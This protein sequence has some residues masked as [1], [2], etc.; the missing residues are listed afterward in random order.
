VLKNVAKSDDFVRDQDICG[1]QYKLLKTVKK[2]TVMVVK[3]LMH[4]SRQ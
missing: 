2:F 3:G 1:Q 4:L